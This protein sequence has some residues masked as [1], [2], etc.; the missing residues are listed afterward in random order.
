MMLLRR[1]SAWMLVLGSLSRGGAIELQTM[2]NYVT[3]VI[4]SLDDL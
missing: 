4:L 2:S 1:I 3:I